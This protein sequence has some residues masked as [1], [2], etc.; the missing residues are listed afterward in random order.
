MW[1]ANI[2]G[3]IL[4][5]NEVVKLNLK[6]SLSFFAAECAFLLLNF[7]VFLCFILFLQIF[8]SFLLNLEFKF[9]WSNQIHGYEN[10]AV[11]VCFVNKPYSSQFYPPSLPLIRIYS[12][13]L[14]INHFY[15]YWVNYS[16]IIHNLCTLCQ[17]MMIKFHSILIMCD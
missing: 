17:N 15:I 10:W 11:L 3:W 14:K 13:T 16:E 2:Y 1:N 12:E 8:M 7:L 5:R 6:A 9:S 4:L